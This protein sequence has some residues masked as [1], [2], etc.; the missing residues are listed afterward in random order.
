MARA[1]E[2]G[3]AMK[4]AEQRSQLTATGAEKKSGDR[5]EG[6]R[7]ASRRWTTEA[8]G[9]PCAIELAVDGCW[10]VT[11]ASA[12]TCRRED[13]TAAISEASGGLVSNAEAIELAA[14]VE[15]AC[16]SRPRAG[17]AVDHQPEGQNHAGR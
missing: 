4:P 2:D 14:A 5:Q 10:V 15:N 13:L 1:H 16:D 9:L 11:I 6:N 7:R 3:E 17:R 8:A 12:S